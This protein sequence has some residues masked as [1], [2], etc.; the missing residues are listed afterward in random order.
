MEMVVMQTAVAP[1]TEKPLINRVSL[2][3]IVG[4]IGS[5]LI[6][7]CS[8]QSSVSARYLTAEKLWTEKKYEASV[9]E[10]DRIVKESPGSAIGLQSLWRASLTRSLFLKDYPEA[11]K[12]LQAFIDQ[13]AQPNLILEA[14]K[15]IGEILYSKTQQY[16]AAIDHYSKLI[17][18]GKYPEDEG[19]FRYRISRC[20]VS[21]GKIKK[22]IQIQ[23]EILK[24][25]KDSELVQKTKMDIAQN[26][27]T[28]G[29]VEKQAYAKA[30]EYY[31][32]ISIE[33]KGKNRKRF[34]EALF[35]MAVVLEEMDKPEEAVEL[36]KMIESDYH[37]PNIVKI[38][39]QKINERNK[40]K[41]I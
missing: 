14:Q 2:P 41:K 38:R 23:E 39:I 24:S 26:W 31:K 19:A 11:L 18:T 21:L 29:D 35:G 33:T 5:F 16:Q 40:R 6:A 37:Y 12:G 15:E 30:I 34:A 13:S 10:F 22:A 8:S 1:P 27:F 20:Y 9:V 36:Y 4:L 32:Q 28:I 3:I 25:S 7:S 17:E